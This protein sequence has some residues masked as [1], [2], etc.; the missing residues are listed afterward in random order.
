MLLY[1]YAIVTFSHALRAVN[2]YGNYSIIY[3]YY[4]VQIVPQFPRVKLCLQMMHNL[5]STLSH[6]ESVRYLRA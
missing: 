6:A 4:S 3:R 1:G 2:W 5:Y